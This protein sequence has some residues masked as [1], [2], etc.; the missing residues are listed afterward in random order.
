MNSYA[1][2]DEKKW[3]GRLMT[4]WSYNKRWRFKKFGDENAE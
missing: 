2:D 4:I 1:G 3:K